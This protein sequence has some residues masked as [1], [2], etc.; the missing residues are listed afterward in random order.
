[1]QRRKF[2]R[3]LLGGAA[4]VAA[5]PLALPQRADGLIIGGRV[6][7]AEPDKPQV[8]KS[9]VVSGLAVSNALRRKTQLPP[10]KNMSDVRRGEHQRGTYTGFSTQ[11]P[12]ELDR[13]NDILTLL[14]PYHRQMV[15]SMQQVVDHDAWEFTFTGP[16][17]LVDEAMAVID[18]FEETWSNPSA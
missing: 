9:G 17:A 12:L 1:M 5:A 6:D 15:W 8:T 13:D 7:S 11:Q 3:G 4:V 14:A 16:E 2:L 18:T 10:A